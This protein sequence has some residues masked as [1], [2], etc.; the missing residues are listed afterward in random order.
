MKELKKII[1]ESKKLL[2][3][4]K[5]NDENKK[6]TSADEVLKR[7]NAEA[8]DIKKTNESLKEYY[9]NEAQKELEAEELDRTFKELIN[10]KKYIDPQSRVNAMKKN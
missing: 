10:K 3:T 4:I 1:D 5:K 7:L 2:K 8:E 9:T 6:Y